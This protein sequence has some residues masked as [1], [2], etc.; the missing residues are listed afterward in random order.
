MK[1]R[2]RRGSY[3]IEWGKGGSRRPLAPH[4]NP[5]LRSSLINGCR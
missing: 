5:G 1:R 3:E 4:P 2:K